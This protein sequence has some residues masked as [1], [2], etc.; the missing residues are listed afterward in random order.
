MRTLHS[1]F[2][3]LYLVFTAAIA[4]CM[5]FGNLQEIIDRWC[6]Q[7]TLMMELSTLSTA[8]AMA[9]CGISALILSVGL[10]Y[11]FYF[12]KNEKTKHA[13]LSIAAIWVFI[14]ISLVFEHHTTVESC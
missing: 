9:Y 12:Y 3:H 14:L 13:L 10:G 8:N 7:H 5:I 2:Y 4:L 6:G 11:V 1:I